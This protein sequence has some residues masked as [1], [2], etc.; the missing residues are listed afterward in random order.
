MKIN[1][2]VFDSENKEFVKISNGI[3]KDGKLIPTEAIALR[4]I[5][6]MSTGRLEVAFTYRKV[7]ASRLCPLTRGES[8][9][10]FDAVMERH[11]GGKHFHYIGRV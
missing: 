6:V 7:D 8:A 3:E 5:D 4:I 9:T 10:L 1:Q 2:V 11:D